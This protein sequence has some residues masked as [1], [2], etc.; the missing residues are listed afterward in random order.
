M[1]VKIAINNAMEV[2]FV[3]LSI[4]ALLL[5]WSIAPTDSTLLSV[6]DEITWYSSLTLFTTCK[7]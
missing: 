4:A 5:V 3:P 6:D 1:S 2:N 7:P